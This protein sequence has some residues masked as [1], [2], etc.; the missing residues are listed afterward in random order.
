MHRKVTGI[1]LHHSTFL[2]DAVRGGSNMLAGLTNAVRRTNSPELKALLEEARALVQRV[3]EAHGRASA[4]L[5]DLQADPQ[6]K[7]Y[8]DG[9][10]PWP[11][12][13]PEGFVARCSC[14]DLC[15]FH[16]V[17]RGSWD[18]NCSCRPCPQHGPEGR[19]AA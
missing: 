15:L 10:L 2:D 18:D 4:S 14:D 5:R 17:G 16:D 19:A 8:R 9:A 6:F 13:V 7:Q 12:E 1:Q 3:G 11:D